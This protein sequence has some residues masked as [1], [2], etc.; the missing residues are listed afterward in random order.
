MARNYNDFEDEK[1]S[2]GGFER[3][4]MLMIPIIFT[5]VLLGV[6]LVLFN[7]NIRNAFFEVANKIPIVEK[8]VPDP[9]L[10]PETIKL[11]ESEKEEEDNDVKIKELQ[12]QL[13]AKEAELQQVNEGK[14]EQEAQL[15]NLQSQIEVLEQ[16]SVDKATQ[17]IADEYQKQIDNLAKMYA[18]MSPSKAAPILQNMT[19][20]EMVLLF[21][22]MKN[23]NRIAILEKM[24]SKVAAEVTMMM[25][26]VKPATDLQIAALQSRLKQNDTTTEETST[27]LNNS[28]LSQTFANMSADKAA[29]LLF[30]T[31]KISPDKT[32]E[33]LSSVTDATRSSILEKMSTIDAPT[34]AII[35]NKLMSK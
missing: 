7:M 11:K 19:S 21:S 32:L 28:Q 27:I 31:Y 6:L 35:L 34:T 1:E 25:K 4:L 8:W 9:V 33:I 29:E 3:F 23:D 26:D 30:Q 14:V 15:E 20:E 10:D 5:I 16:E 2:N 17:E 13:S 18:D 22:S 12:N 24:D